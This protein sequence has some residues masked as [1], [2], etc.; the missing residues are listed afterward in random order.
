MYDYIRG[1]IVE[2]SPL[3]VVIENNG[4][5][6]YVNISL[7]TFTSLG[8][9]KSAKI[10]TYQYLVRDDLPIL[11]GFFSKNEREMF[12]LLIAVS[13]VGANTA[14]TILSTFSINDLVSLISTGNSSALK[15]VKGLGTKTSE[16]V[17]VELRDK[18]SQIETDGTI[19][20]EITKSEPLDMDIFDEA[21]SAL[22][23][24]GFSKAASTK[25]IKSIMSENSSYK[26]EDVIRYSLKKL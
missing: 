18:V 7:Q 2:I 25:A 16:K 17:I 14:R 13:G 3:N 23:M 1:E 26:V 10:Y 19:S 4:I 8:G 12:K 11:Y 9:E 21:L 20:G 24:L 15:T 6:Y 22:T 5:G